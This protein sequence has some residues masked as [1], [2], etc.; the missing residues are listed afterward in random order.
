MDIKENL[1]KYADFKGRTSRRDFWKFILAFGL[2]FSALLMFEG[3]MRGPESH[4]F[5]KAFEVIMAIPFLAI[6]ARRLHD[7]DRSGWFQLLSLIPVVGSI[8]MLVFFLKKGTP[9]P[10]R[11]GPAP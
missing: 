3:P 4:F 11:F 1:K 5:S 6:G 9:G 8:V 10:N 7:I 2:I